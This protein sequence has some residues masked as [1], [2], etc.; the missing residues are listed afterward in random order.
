RS[1][2]ATAV[3]SHSLTA[4]G[5]PKHVFSWRRGRALREA[6]L[7]FSGHDDDVAVGGWFDATEG[8]ER[9]F[10]ERAIDFYSSRRFV[11]TDGGLQIIEV[12]DDCRVS[13]HRE[14]LLLMPRTEFG[15]IPAG[16]LAVALFD[17]WLA[18]SRD[19]RILFAPDDRTSLQSVAWTKGHLVLTLLQ[20]VA[21]RLVT[22]SIGDWA[23]GEIPGLPESASV[24]VVGTS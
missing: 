1:L 3:G 5:Y 21:T 18:G 12:P 2:A 11:R 19:S 15:G 14:Y 7:V 17:D 4:A 16:G 24:S 22:L 10:V 13:V 23:E 9:L 8:F 20:D 6:E